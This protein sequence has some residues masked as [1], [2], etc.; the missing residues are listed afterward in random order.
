MELSSIWIRS[1]CGW[2]LNTK[3]RVYQF[4]KIKTKP[5]R[6]YEYFNLIFCTNF[7]N[8]LSK[9]C[10]GPLA[11]SL[12]PYWASSISDAMTSAQQ[13]E[14]ADDSLKKSRQ[15]TPSFTRKRKAS[16]G[17]KYTAQAR[18]YGYGEKSIRSFS[19]RLEIPAE[20]KHGE[21][22]DF[23]RR[24]RTYDETIDYMQYLSGRYPSL[25]HV[26]SIGKSFEGRSINALVLRRSKSKPARSMLVTSGVHG[27]EWTPISGTL[28]AA[29]Q[30]LASAASSKKHALDLL[31]NIEL[32]IIPIVNPDG[33]AYTFSDAKFKKQ[34]WQGGSLVEETNEARYWRKNRGSN[35]DGSRGVD[36]NRNFGTAVWGRD[37]KTKSMKLTAGDVYQGPKGFSEPESK[38]VAR[39]AERLRSTLTAFFDVHCCIGA[40]LEPYSIVPLSPEH[41]QGIE[42]GQGHC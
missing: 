36:L 4:F 34:K 16:S 12:S 9:Q 11:L 30:L 40:I 20:C 32:H 42:N 19:K 6:A 35:A 5:L 28:Y 10:A 38:T 1:A 14:D 21:T 13:F 15:D 29:T 17:I 2:G 18:A 41:R 7:Q 23:F 3:R 31:N 39:Y 25:A 26:V 27:R 37:H 22:G 24:F 8:E 33:Y